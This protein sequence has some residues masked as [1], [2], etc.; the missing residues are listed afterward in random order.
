MWHPC[1]CVFLRET[2]WTLQCI[3]PSELHFPAPSPWNVPS[4]DPFSFPTAVLPLPHHCLSSCLLMCNN[5][6]LSW[7]TPVIILTP[8]EIYGYHLI[9]AFGLCGPFLL[10][11]HQFLFLVPTGTRSDVSILTL[12]ASLPHLS[13]P[14]N[15]LASNF[16]EKTRGHRA[17]LSE[18]LNSLPTSNF[19]GLL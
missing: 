13:V 8:W 3:L 1:R 2:V 14:A 19:S 5:L 15:V 18:F 10:L 9:W 16:R 4:L 6:W 12:P 11:P 7:I 17:L